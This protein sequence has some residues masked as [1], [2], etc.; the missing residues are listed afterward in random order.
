MSEP[1]KLRAVDADDLA[2]I[3]A[4]LQDALVPVQDMCFLPDERR[5]VLVANRFRWENLSG[6]APDRPAEGAST[7]NA[8]QSSGVYERVHCGVTFEHVNRV[9]T[10]GFTAGAADD[11]GR[12]LEILAI[13]AED[14]ELTLVFSGNAALRMEVDGIDAYVQDMGEPWPTV[15]RPRHPVADDPSGVGED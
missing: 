8:G 7:P 14:N 3:G 10:L 6:S 1:L 13:M 2:V 11:Q 15:W 9:Q 12:L 4:C 5:F